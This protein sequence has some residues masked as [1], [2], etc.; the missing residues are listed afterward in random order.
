MQNVF[1]LE[2]YID[3]SVQGLSI[4]SPVM[5]RGVQIGSVK[6]I[7]FVP[8]EYPMY[9]GTEEYGKYGKY[10]MVIM[11]IERENFM[12]LPQDDMV[13][14]TI[15]NRLIEENGLRLKLAY[16]GI[17]G[18][19]YVE[20][21]Y[22]D[23]QRYE[24]MEIGWEPKRTYIPSAPSTLWSFTQS[25]DT[26]LQKLDSID[27]QATATLL[28]QTL[29]S[30]NNAVADA[31]IPATRQELVGLFSEIRETN[32]FVL[33]LMDESKGDESAVNIPQTIAQF[34]KTLKRMD[35]FVSG[36]QGEV[37]EVMANIKRVSANLRELTEY[38]KKYPSQVLFGSPPS[39]SEVIK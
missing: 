2:T 33:M 23:P 30:I 11:A 21:D 3:E 24:P 7:T 29:D 1:W 26:I 22:V 12:D 15:L 25:V 38:A 31:N 20:A 34:N 35:D 17:T 39:R 14:K 10:V 9:Y 28:D 18:V 19:A 37:E 4:G 36:Q 16:Q 5:Q 32:K 8:N 6:E 27:F 13:A